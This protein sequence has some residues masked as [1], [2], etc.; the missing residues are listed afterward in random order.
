MHV[1]DFRGKCPLDESVLLHLVEALELFRHYE[2]F[3]HGAT[4]ARNIFNFNVLSAQ[5][6]PQYDFHLTFR[7]PITTATEISPKAKLAVRCSGAAALSRSNNPSQKARRRNE[8]TQ[9]VHEKVRCVTGLRYKGNNSYRKKKAK[10]LSFSFLHIIPKNRTER[11]FLFFL[12]LINTKKFQWLVGLVICH[13]HY[14]K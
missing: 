2:H 6:I 14:S 7:G 13:P 10:Y 11:V 9:H 4:P 3:I 8:G 5:L 12:C 1:C